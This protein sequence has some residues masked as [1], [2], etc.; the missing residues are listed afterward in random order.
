MT[1]EATKNICVKGTDDENIVNS[2]RNF[3][4]FARH[5]MIR[6]GQVGIKI[7]N[8]E[9]MLQVIEANP[10]WHLKTIRRTQHIT[11]QWG[12]SPS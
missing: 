3:A 4:Q 9:A 1:P 7:V 10:E 2:S 5:S 12:S 11:V 8:S 6:Q